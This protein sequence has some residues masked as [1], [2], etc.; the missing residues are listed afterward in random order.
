[1]HSDLCQDRETS[2]KVK[3]WSYK[4]NTQQRKL[5]RKYSQNTIEE[6]VLKREK[7]PHCEAAGISKFGDG[8]QAN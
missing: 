2:K 6:F 4:R 8:L 1:M 3:C 7:I 5:L